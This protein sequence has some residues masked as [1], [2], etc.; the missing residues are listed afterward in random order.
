L[1]VIA[2]FTGLLG[3][4]PLPKGEE[5][6]IVSDAIHAAAL[7]DG[8][9]KSIPSKRPSTKDPMS[10][11][12]VPSSKKRRLN[13]KSMTTFSNIHEANAGSADSGLLS[14]PVKRERTQKQRMADLGNALRGMASWAIA[15]GDIFLEMAD[16]FD[17]E[18]QKTFSGL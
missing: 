13:P 9:I 11:E 18:E 2:N 8:V 16:G 1:W 7:E 4:P 17:D 14:R 5:K 12:P 15:A 6:S 10:K 3:N